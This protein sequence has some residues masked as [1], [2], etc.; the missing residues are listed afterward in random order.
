[1]SDLIETIRSIVQKELERTRRFQLTHIRAEPGRDIVIQN[2]DG[3]TVI[4]L[5]SDGTLIIS[6]PDRIIFERKAAQ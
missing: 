5:K 3:N 4:T 6:A 2:T 1:M